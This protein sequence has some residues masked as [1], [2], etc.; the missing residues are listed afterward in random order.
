[1][2]RKIART[3][4]RKSQG[5]FIVQAYDQYGKRWPEA[6]YYTDDAKDAKETAALMVNCQQDNS[7]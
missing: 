6:D 4:I 3:T 2:E 1:M 7:Q 5:E